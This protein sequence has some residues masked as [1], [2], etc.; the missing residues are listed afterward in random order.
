MTASPRPRSRRRRARRRLDDDTPLPVRFTVS[1][2]APNRRLGAERLGASPASVSA[3][4][5]GWRLGEPVLAP[6]HTAP[7]CAPGLCLSALQAINYAHLACTQ[8]LARPRPLFRA[9]YLARPR[10]PTLTWRLARPRPEYRLR[11]PARIIICTFVIIFYDNYYY[12]CSIIID[13]IPTQIVLF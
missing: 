5:A 8:R 11:R 10:S 4:L 3:H 12:S 13:V 1:Q 9:Q 2:R 7:R 6:Q